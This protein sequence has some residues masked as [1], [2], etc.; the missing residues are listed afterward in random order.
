ME[1]SVL[2]LLAEDSEGLGIIAAAVQ[3]GLV[4]PQDIKYDK[5]ARAFEAM[6]KEALNWIARRLSAMGTTHPWTVLRARELLAWIDDGSYDKL[7][8]ADHGAALPTTGAA[9]CSGCGAKL[10]DGVVF[11]PGCGVKLRLAAPA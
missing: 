11:C 10:G 3:D 8:T 6:D 5:Q 1:A 4:K 9:F 7:L 2:K